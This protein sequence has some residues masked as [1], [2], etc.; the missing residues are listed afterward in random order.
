MRGLVDAKN[1]LFNVEK[2]PF[3]V[4]N[5]LFN[6]ENALFNVKNTLF[7]IENT[8]FDVKN[9]L[10]DVEN[11]LFNVENALFNVENA[12]FD[13]EKPTMSVLEPGFVARFTRLAGFLG[14]ACFASTAW[15]VGIDQK[16]CKSCK[17]YENPGSRNHALAPKSCK[18]C[19]SC[20]ESWLKNAPLNKP[21]GQQV[22]YVQKADEFAFLV[23]NGQLVHLELLHTSGRCHGQLVGYGATRLF[24]HQLTHG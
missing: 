15:H 17:S 20:Y 22:L 24:L 10:F 12:L 9:A 8:L 16:S 2:P 23:D 4:G 5:T 21:N 7:S 11:A 1:T 13:V 14:S 6:V 3:N 19:K 18:S